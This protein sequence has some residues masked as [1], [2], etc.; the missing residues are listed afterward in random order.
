MWRIHCSPLSSRK[1]LS[2]VV[3][4]EWVKVGSSDSV[5][6]L[7]NND[8]VGASIFHSNYKLITTGIMGGTYFSP[9]TNETCSFLLLTVDWQWLSAWFSPYLWAEMITMAWLGSKYFIESHSIKVKNVK[10]RFPCLELNPQC[11]FAYRSSA[12]AVAV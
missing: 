1:L 4:M 10:Y 3:Y 6:K 11:T 8:C 12:A 7:K 2:I 5:W 9:C